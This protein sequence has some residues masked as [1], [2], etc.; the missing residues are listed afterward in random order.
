MASVVCGNGGS[1][2]LGVCFPAAVGN[3]TRPPPPPGPRQKVVL[4]LTQ[5]YWRPVPSQAPRGRPVP[6]LDGRVVT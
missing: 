1:S 5:S 4:H 3:S 2:G 6:A